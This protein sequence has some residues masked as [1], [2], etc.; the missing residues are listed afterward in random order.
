MD[1]EKTQVLNF[2]A[3]MLS[4]YPEDRRR[5][6]M[7]S[8]YLCD[9]TMAIFEA[10]VPNSGFRAGKF[11]QR[12]RVRNPETKKFF[13]PEAFYVGAKIQASGRVFELLDAAP[14]TF[15]LMEA[16]SD[17]F[18]DADISSVV[19]KLS[20]VCMGQTKNLR[21]LFENYDKAKTGIVEK[22]EAEQ[23]LSSFQPELSR[24]S[25]VTILRAFEEKGRFNYDPLLKYI[26]Q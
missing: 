24:H 10:N 25:I 21:P 26:K 6:F 2:K 14:H 13:E 9:K 17:Q 15:C 18:P 3:K 12:T 7:I 20:Q 8:Y 4:D 23:V 11:L 19:N 16:N 5:Q 1:D 22:S